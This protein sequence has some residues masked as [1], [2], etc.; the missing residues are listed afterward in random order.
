M[1]DPL[2]AMPVAP[3]T[4]VYVEDRRGEVMAAF[5]EKEKRES[6]A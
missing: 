2:V 5:D 3:T 1:L 4:H 6:N